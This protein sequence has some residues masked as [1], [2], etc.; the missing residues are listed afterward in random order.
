VGRTL[1]AVG[2]GP[3]P[4]N[5]P[6]SLYLAGPYHGSAISLVAIDAVQVGPFDLG[7]VVVREAFDVDPASGQV[8]L[9]AT[10]SDPIP[11]I[12]KGIPVHARV[13]SVD[14]DRD[15]F[16][17]NPTSCER[18]SVASTVLGSGRDFASAADD[19]PFTVT[20]PFQAAD[21]AA[22]P[23]GPKLSLRLIGATHRGAFPQL[24]ARLRTAGIG[25]AAI[26]SAQITLPHSEFLANAHID[27]ICTRAQYRAKACPP[28]SIYG[29]ATAITPLMGETLSGPVYLRSSEHRLPDL[30]ASLANSK[31]EIELVGRVD[32]AA[33][34]AIR[35]GFSSL[36]DAPVSEFQ[37]TMAGARRGLLENSVDICR[38][39]H[40]ARLS[41]GAHNGKALFRRPPLE[42]SCGPAPSRSEGT[43]GQSEGTR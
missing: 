20:S 13:I 40:R 24:R 41:L 25:T 34:G 8:F 23:F 17:L 42:A 31:L 26:K 10:G 28:G 36:P 5:T 38:H 16:A 19:F 14:V 39:A 27:T 29:H 11:H 3:T 43:P 6:G 9:D 4:T 37:L 12:I 15:G 7:T 18:T 1:T 22:L 21:C 2:V 33:G 32:S 30:V 35:V